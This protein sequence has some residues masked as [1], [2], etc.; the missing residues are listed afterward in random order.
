M[1]STLAHA[2]QDRFQT[3]PRD[4]AHFCDSAALDEFIGVCKRLS[5]ICSIEDSRS[6]D[7]ALL[8]AFSDGSRLDVGN[9]SQRVYPAF[10]KEAH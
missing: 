5:V 6:C 7:S 10:A 9:P 2:L 4:S 8:F 1:S 3:I